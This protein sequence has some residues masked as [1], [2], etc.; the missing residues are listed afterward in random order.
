MNIDEEIKIWTIRCA[1]ISRKLNS[2]LPNEE[3]IV[4]EVYHECG[5][6]IL[7]NLSKMQRLTEKKELEYDPLS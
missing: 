2:N 3:R 4:L 5:I 6:A 7:A 1:K